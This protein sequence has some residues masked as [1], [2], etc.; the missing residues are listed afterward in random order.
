MGFYET[1]DGLTRGAC[2]EPLMLDDRHTVLPQE[3]EPV[4]LTRSD[5][6]KAGDLRDAP[7]VPRGSMGRRTRRSWYV[8]AAAGAILVGTGLWSSSSHMAM[9]ERGTVPPS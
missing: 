6:G 5:I 7:N 4:P 2:K 8:A 1:M 9:P 3:I